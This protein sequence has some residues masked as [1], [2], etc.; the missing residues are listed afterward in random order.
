M[1]F[2]LPPPRIWVEDVGGWE[3]GDLLQPP[4]FCHGEDGPETGFSPKHKV[5]SDHLFL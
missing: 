1:Q 5:G 4:P 2:P 3:G